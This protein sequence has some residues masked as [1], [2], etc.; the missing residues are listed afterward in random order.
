LELLPVSAR[1]TIIVPYELVTVGSDWSAL[2][3]AL[4]DWILHAAP[5]LPDG[6]HHIGMPERELRCTARK[7]STG[8]PRVVL[9][10]FAPDE[11]GLTARLGQQIR[12]KAAKL[13]RYKKQ[14]YTTVLLLETRDS[15]LMHQ[16]M[17]LEAVRE[18]MHGALPPDVDQVWYVELEGRVAIDLTAALADAQDRLR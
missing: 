3:L 5:S 8:E 12:R 18:C 16:Y 2:R 14:G 10:R 6:L 4:A 13:A 1:L 7:D 11:A 15:A 17:M 9:Q